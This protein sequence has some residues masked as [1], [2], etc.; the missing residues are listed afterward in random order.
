MM[1][2]AL[3]NNKY[4]AQVRNRVCETQRLLYEGFLQWQ[5]PVSEVHKGKEDLIFEIAFPYT[6][7]F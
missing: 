3:V 7:V 4:K 2:F 5:I 1:I 6:Y